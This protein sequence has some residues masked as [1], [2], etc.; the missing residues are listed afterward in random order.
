MKISTIAAALLISASMLVGGQAMAGAAGKVTKI[1]REGRTVHIG[2][3]AV[4]IS[5]SRTKVTIKGKEADRGEIKVGMSCTA[6]VDSG[7]AKMVACK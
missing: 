4:K 6:D 3:S 5:G 1:E 2:T 7:R